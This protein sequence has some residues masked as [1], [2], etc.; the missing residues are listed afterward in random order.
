MCFFILNFIGGKLKGVP[1]PSPRRGFKFGGV[2]ENFKI[3]DLSISDIEQDIQ[4]FQ[5]RISS[6]R[7][8]LAMLPEGHLPYSE[9]RKREKLKRDLQNDIRHYKQLIIYAEEGLER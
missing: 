3:M 7:K 8:K 4:A 9:Y 6:A 5:E 1:G 2:F